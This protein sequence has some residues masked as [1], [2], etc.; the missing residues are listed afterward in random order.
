MRDE[1]LVTVATSWAARAPEAAG[2]CMVRGF[3]FHFAGG[4]RRRGG[5]VGDAD[6]VAY[7]VEA[8]YKFT[9]K[10]FG[11]LRWNQQFFAA[12]PDGAGERGLTHAFGAQFTLRF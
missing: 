2:A 1:A 10:F 9:P 7:G 3:R 6:S 4:A 5:R 11:A 8:K 12:V